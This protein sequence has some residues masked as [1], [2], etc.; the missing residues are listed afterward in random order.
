[1]TLNS[2]VMDRGDVE[3]DDVNFPSVNKSDLKTKIYKH[4]DTARSIR[5]LKNIT[6]IILGKLDSFWVH[7]LIVWIGNI[8]NSSRLQM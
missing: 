7:I 3:D 4:L 1:M 2:Y 5:D 8:L 6:L